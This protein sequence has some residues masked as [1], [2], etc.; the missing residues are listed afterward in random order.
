M[1]LYQASDLCLVWLLRRDIPVASSP[2]TALAEAPHSLSAAEAE[3]G[4]LPFIKGT[5]ECSEPVTTMYKRHLSLSLP[6][7]AAEA[8][9]FLYI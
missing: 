1:S 9:S 6:I 4:L 5:S 7:T 8:V 3:Q 2:G